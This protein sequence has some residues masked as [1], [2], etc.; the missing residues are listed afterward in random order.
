MP[1]T[2]QAGHWFG[3]IWTE[4]KLDAV[5]YYLGFFTRVLE[6]KPF[7]LWYIDA[8]AG[9]GKRTIER[10]TG[11]LLEETPLTKATE[12]LAGSVLRA[13]DVTP[14]FSRHVFIEGNAGRFQ[15]LEDIRLSRPDKR[16]ECRH[17]DANA[18]LQTIFST[19]P[20]RSQANGRGKLRAVVFLDPYGM[21][22]AWST[23]GL[24]S[25]TKAVDVWYL[26]PLSAVT[27]QLALDADSID[28][29]K[30]Q[31]LDSIFGTSKWRDEL[32]NTSTTVDL[33]DNLVTSSKRRVSQKQIE[34]Y[35]R[36]RLGTLFR[37]VSD[38]LPLIADG[39]GH[40]F[41]LFCLSNSESDA[42]I[43]LIKKGVKATL[44]K[45]GG[46]ASH[47]TSGH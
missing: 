46:R 27:R 5:H 40:L 31:S 30:S 6:T 18:E 35:S 24:L 17:G 13:L 10:E 20:W 42:A 37:Y 7:D 45:Y 22:V 25:S 4:L 43:S 11:G 15:E 16:I 12:E 26:F 34:T 8:F 33:F 21:N 14:P 29:H 1:R 2:S 36:T 38:P 19:A 32:Y 44:K 47:R 23:L 39:R 3:G 9:S 28:I 41:S